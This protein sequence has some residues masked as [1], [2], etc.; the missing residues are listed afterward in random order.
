MFVEVLLPPDSPIIL[1]FRHHRCLIPTAPLLTGAPN[2]R[3]VRRLGHF[4]PISQCIS[5]PVQDMAIVATE[6]E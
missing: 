1:V 6:V 2:A 5:E 3:E 4:R